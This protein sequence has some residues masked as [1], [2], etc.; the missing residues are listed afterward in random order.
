M[1]FD[2]VISTNSG[3]AA[4]FSVSEGGIMELAKISVLDEA[5]ED[6]NVVII[7]KVVKAW[8]RRSATGE[9]A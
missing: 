6:L 5:A 3:A 9:L 7:A 8:I 1:A 4:T 2:F